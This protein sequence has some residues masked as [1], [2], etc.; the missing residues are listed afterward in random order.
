MVSLNLSKVI[1]AMGE[2]DLTTKTIKKIAIEEIRG[3][4]IKLK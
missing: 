2:V 4:T 1:E 3:Q